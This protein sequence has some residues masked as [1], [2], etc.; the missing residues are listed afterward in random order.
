MPDVL[1]GA[2]AIQ[3]EKQNCRAQTGDKHHQYLLL[4]CTLY[5]F[6]LTA[7]VLH[8]TAVV[9]C[10]LPLQ[11]IAQRNIVVKSFSNIP[12][13]DLEMIFP[14]K[15]VYIKPFVLIQLIVTVVLA[16]ITVFTTLW[17]VAIL[18]AML[19]YAT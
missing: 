15:K 3:L 18:S 14:E 16:A 10:L 9:S 7:V 1:C 2:A 12:L 5:A 11:D 6:V 17:Q 19:E 8:D 4:G 13:A